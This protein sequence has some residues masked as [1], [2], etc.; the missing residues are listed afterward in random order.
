MHSFFD[1]CK[2]LPTNF[3]KCVLY[4]SDDN[5]VSSV[6]LDAYFDIL[7]VNIVSK[8]SMHSM[9]SILSLVKSIKAIKY[10]KEILLTKKEVLVLVL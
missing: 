1:K 2:P 6:A 8:N 4:N 9:K 7:C 5:N 10:V 3:R